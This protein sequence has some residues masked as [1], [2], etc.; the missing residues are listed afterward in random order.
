MLKRSWSARKLSLGLRWQRN[1]ETS[2]DWF[3]WLKLSPS[4]IQFEVDC[5]K[6]RYPCCHKDTL[7]ECPVSQVGYQINDNHLPLFPGQLRCNLT[8]MPAS[9]HLPPEPIICFWLQPTEPCLFAAPIQGVSDYSQPAPH[10]SLD[11]VIYNL[12]LWLWDIMPDT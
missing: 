3:Q 9:M 8:F 11:S 6:I 2:E 5:I 1:Q 10:P 4:S 7:L 12:K